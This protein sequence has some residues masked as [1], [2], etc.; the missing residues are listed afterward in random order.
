MVLFCFCFYFQSV[1]WILQ[2]K[3]QNN[4][5]SKSSVSF[6]LHCALQS[7]FTTRAQDHF[8]VFWLKQLPVPFMSTY[9]PLNPWRSPRCAVPS[10]FFL[11]LAQRNQQKIRIKDKMQRP[12]WEKDKLILYESRNVL[13]WLFQRLFRFE[14]LRDLVMIVE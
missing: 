8:S 6:T 7:F 9:A 2:S 10:C 12:V 3:T 5:Y 14:L 4:L 1:Y 13:C 11:N